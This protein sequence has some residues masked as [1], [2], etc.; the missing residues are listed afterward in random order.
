MDDYKRN[1]DAAQDGDASFRIRS[2]RIRLEAGLI[3]Q[4]C[5]SGS[6]DTHQR[7]NGETFQF[8]WQLAYMEFYLQTWY[9]WIY[10]AELVQAIEKY[11]QR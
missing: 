2:Q 4:E 11:N 5:R 10:K 9:A 1:A 7:E 3:L 8:M 6:S